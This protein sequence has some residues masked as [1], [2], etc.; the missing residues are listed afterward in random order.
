MSTFSFTWLGHATFLFESPG[1]KRIVLDPWITG[2]PSSPDSAKKLGALDLILISHGHS[3]HMGYEG[4][5]DITHTSHSYP[6][7]GS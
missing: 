2:N 3:D 6:R 1:G 7:A 5:C 4:C